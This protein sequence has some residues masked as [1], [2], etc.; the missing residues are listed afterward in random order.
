MGAGVLAADE[1]AR[2]S[3]ARAGLVGAVLVFVVAAQ[4]VGIARLLVRG[5]YG[6]RV[7]ARLLQIKDR[8][9]IGVGNLL[10]PLVSRSGASVN[11]RGAPRP[12]YI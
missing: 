12:S 2:G 9:P 3:G 7:R 11:A 6:H 5:V 10:L 1:D 8:R 4:Q